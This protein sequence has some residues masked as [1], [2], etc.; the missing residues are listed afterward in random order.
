MPLARLLAAAALA[1]VPLALPAIAA[2][3]QE[4]GFLDRSLGLRGHVYRY[5]VFVPAGFGRERSLP[6]VLFLHG[7]GERGDDGMRATQVGLGAAIR[8]DRT[9]APF[10]AVFPQAPADSNWFGEPGEAALA[11]LDSAVA[12]FGGDTEGA[13]DQVAPG[14]RRAI[15]ARAHAGIGL[16]EARGAE[17]GDAGDD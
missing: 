9:R 12:E 8:W 13:A 17:V 11:A 10:I 5:Q 14:S 16:A 15:D 6:V 2:A 7:A 3:R 4:T 1:L